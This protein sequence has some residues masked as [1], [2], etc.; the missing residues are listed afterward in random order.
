MCF[1][2]IL[3]LLEHK[4]GGKRVLASCDG[5]MNWPQRG[6]YFFFESWEMRI[7][8]GEGP[9]VV[10]VGTHALTRGSQTTLWNRLSQHRGSIKSGGGNHR[11]SIFRLH[12]GTALINRDA[13]PQAITGTWGKGSIANSDVRQAEKSLEKAVSRHI[14]QMPFL[15][16]A[17]KDAPNPT[18][19]RGIIERNSIALLSNYNSTD[20]ALDPPSLNWLGL[21]AD[22]EFVRRSGL[23][24][25]Q[26]VTEAYDPSFL[27]LLERL[28][29]HDCCC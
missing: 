9:R 24:N 2:T 4:L 21:L 8:S 16:L 28:V 5:R 23:W 14:R 3:D 19:L 11:G 7:H 27:D 26:H 20:N 18:S 10:R 22:R 15:W 13:W 17:V 1:Y 25:V 29:N 6:V 12:V